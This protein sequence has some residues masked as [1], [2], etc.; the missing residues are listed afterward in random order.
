MLW[1]SVVI[2]SGGLVDCEYFAENDKVQGALIGWQGGMEG[3]MVIADILC[4]DT[5]PSGKLGDT[6][7]KSYY[8]FENAKIFE[9][10]FDHLDYED[11][12]YVGYRY[13]ETIPGAAEKVRYP[14][15]F[16]L[17]YTTFEMSGAFCGE[18]D[19]KIVA[20]VTVKNTGDRAGKE[21]VQLYYSAPQ[22]KLGKPSK[23]LAAFAKTKLLAPG[24]SQ[25][26]ALSFNI[27]D[28]ASF[29]DLGKV[30][31]S[32]FVLE[33]GSYKFHLGNSVRNTEKLSYE[34]TLDED[35]TVMQSKSLLTPFK[36]EKRLLADGTYETMPQGEPSY[37]SG[38]NEPTDTKAPEETVMFD[39]IDDI[40]AFVK[41]FT[42]DELIDFLGGH[43]M[44]RSVCNTG[45]FGGLD[46]LAIPP[47]PTAD[48]PAG[49]RLN[50]VTGVYT[51]AWPCAALLAC[52]WNTE[53]IQQVGAAGGAELK[54]NNLG[55][56]L[57]PA[58][59]I[60]RNPLCGRNFEYFSEDPVLAGKCCA[61]EVI[62]IQ[63]NK[64]A[65]SV[66]HFACN[67]RESNR[68]ECDSRVSERALREI[69]LRGFEICVKEA[70]PW[71][72]MSSYNLI[73]GKH[74]STSYELLTEILRGEWGFNGIVTT[75][76]G[77]HSDNSDEILAG[78]DIKMGEGDPAELKAAYESGKITRA[79]LEPC[80]KR[81]IQMTMKFAD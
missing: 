30:K 32:A 12:I 2:N 45:A 68:F 27:S 5:N 48:G 57:A 66:K 51:T 36:L 16:G 75:D 42:V 24:E 43:P 70:D 49:V 21:V 35:V 6:I 13:F 60:H 18:S 81:I 50:L 26:V 64:V 74:T 61:S 44:T 22:G 41:Q 25:T 52:T 7:P 4:G 14:F 72:I 20:A 11:D 78:N 37:D 76:W 1:I 34:Y 80:V 77:V 59:N 8:D 19:G 38:K 10:G 29:D 53:L 69:Y 46:R 47:V 17:S 31:K 71:T 79:D 40:D 39:D 65:V 15:G 63:S 62:G 23:E 28:M 55:V 73:N 56:W 67:N 33:K 9:T 58:M 54:E 3:G